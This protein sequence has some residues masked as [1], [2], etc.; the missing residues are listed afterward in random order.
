MWCCLG[1]KHIHRLQEERSKRTRLVIR[2]T[3]SDAL[4]I[5]LCIFNWSPIEILGYLAGYPILNGLSYR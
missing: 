5:R 1:H 2:L 3:K 4:F